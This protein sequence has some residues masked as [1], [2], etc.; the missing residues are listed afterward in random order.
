MYI[1]ILK[2]EPRLST[3]TSNLKFMPPMP[4]QVHAA[5]AEGHLCDLVKY[6]VEHSIVRTLYIVYKLM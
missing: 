1:V 4:A 5:E 6:L 3:M 2:Y